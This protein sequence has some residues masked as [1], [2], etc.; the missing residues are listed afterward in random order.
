VFHRNVLHEWLR[1]YHHSIS[2][3]QFLFRWLKKEWV[4]VSSRF[5][6]VFCHLPF[7]RGKVVRSLNCCASLPFQMFNKRSKTA[8][9]T[10]Y[11]LF[12][13]FISKNCLFIRINHSSNWSL[14]AIMRKN[15][16]PYTMKL[17]KLFFIHAL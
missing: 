9:D 10:K 17:M 15:K 4:S 11:Y 2:Q 1:Y 7:V 6:I 16:F 5:F 13:F 3:H 8:G 14:L 12:L